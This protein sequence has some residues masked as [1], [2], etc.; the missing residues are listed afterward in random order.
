MRREERIGVIYDIRHTTYDIRYTIGG[1][2]DREG[3]GSGQ[4][5]MWKVGSK[6]IAQGRTNKTWLIK[7]KARQVGDQG[8]EQG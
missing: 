7:K 4:E 6:H 3:R 2:G 1:Q 8:E 5:M